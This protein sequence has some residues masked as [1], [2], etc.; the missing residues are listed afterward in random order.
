[1]FIYPPSSKILKDGRKLVELKE[2]MEE[3]ETYRKKGGGDGVKRE[4]PRGKRDR[5]IKNIYKRRGKDIGR[6]NEEEEGGKRDRVK[7]GGQGGE[8]LKEDLYY[9]LCGSRN[10]K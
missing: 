2:W 7:E 5:R 9:I 4:E 6:K 10:E 8:D 1:M 3:R